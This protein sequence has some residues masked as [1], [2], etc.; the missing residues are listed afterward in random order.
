MLSVAITTP[1]WLRITTFKY[2]LLEEGATKGLTIT[3][4]LQVDTGILMLLKLKLCKPSPVVKLLPA[5]IVC[6]VEERFFTCI[7]P[8][9]Y[10]ILEL[11]VLA[12]QSET[13]L[14]VS[15]KA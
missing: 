3:I 5:P 1:F 2:K 6:F 14:K 12:C 9:G 8:N 7:F 4:P 11:V 10:V 15:S 13:T